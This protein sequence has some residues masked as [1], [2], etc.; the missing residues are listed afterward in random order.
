MEEVKY[1]VIVKRDKMVFYKSAEIREE[2]IQSEMD[3]LYNL[4]GIHMDSFK[5]IIK[6]S[7][8]KDTRKI[9]FFKN[10]RRMSNSWN[11]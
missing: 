2:L 11:R 9:E 3:W 10:I 7:K 5:V 4:S 8:D 1:K 6:K